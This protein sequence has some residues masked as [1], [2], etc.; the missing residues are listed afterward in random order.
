MIAYRAA[1]V[2]GLLAFQFS[3]YGQSSVSVDRPDIKVGDTWVFQRTDLW[4][5]TITVTVVNKV[6]EST[7][8]GHKVERSNSEN[9]ANIGSAIFN[10]DLNLLQYNDRKFESVRTLLSFPLIAGKKWEGKTSGRNI[11]N[12]GNTNDTNQYEVVSFEKVV[13][14]AGSFDAF[15]IV[16]NGDYNNSNGQGTWG[17][18]Q[19]RTYWYAPSVKRFV[20]FE[21]KDTGPRGV[22]N[23]WV[24]ELVKFELAK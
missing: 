24:D 6:V 23:N 3:A 4:S 12:D 18:K 17:G 14:P 2:L 22:W 21:Y 19:F 9:G 11:A 10:K 15:K 8:D 16:A 5:K 13:V 1:L 20:K 7:Q